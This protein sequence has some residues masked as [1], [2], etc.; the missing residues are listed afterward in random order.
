MY[1]SYF[2]YF[3]TGNSIFE[4]ILANLM[5]NLRELI[6]T[7]IARIMTDFLGHSNIIATLALAY[8]RGNNTFILRAGRPRQGQC[9][10]SAELS[11]LGLCRGAACPRPSGQYTAFFVTN[12]EKSACFFSVNELFIANKI[13]YDKESDF[14]PC[15]AP[16]HRA[17]GMGRQ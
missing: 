3:C 11:S 1:L 9:K 12:Q 15:P 10:P 17:G 6:N 2:L 13:H 4:L 7:K 16:C 8:K 14:H 5:T